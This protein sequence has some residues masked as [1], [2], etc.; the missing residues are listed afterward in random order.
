MTIPRTEDPELL[1]MKRVM[2]LLAK[3]DRVTRVRILDYVNAKSANTPDEQPGPQT[4]QTRLPFNTN[5]ADRLPSAEQGGA[6]PVA[7]A[8]VGTVNLDQPWSSFSAGPHH[9]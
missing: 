2:R 5:V 6:A 4:P 3:H 9:E 1:T 8:L 7:Q